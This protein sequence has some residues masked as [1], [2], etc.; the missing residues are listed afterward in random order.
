[1]YYINEKWFI[2]YAKNVEKN[3]NFSWLLPDIGVEIGLSSGCDIGLL[4]EATL[5]PVQACVFC[6]LRFELDI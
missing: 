1:M 6:D 3:L 5:L 2:I 4:W